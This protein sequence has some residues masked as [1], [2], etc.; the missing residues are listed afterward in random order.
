[1]KKLNYNI[2]LI[3]FILLIMLF[4][5]FKFLVVYSTN[6]KLPKVS[7]GNVGNGLCRIAGNVREY[8]SETENANIEN[9]KIELLDSDEN[10]IQL[11]D[12][13]GNPIDCI[14]SD[15]NVNYQITGIETPF[16]GINEN[17]TNVIEEKEY[18]VQFTYG[19]KEQLQINSKYN[20]Q[21]YQTKSEEGSSPSISSDKKDSLEDLKEIVKSESEIE[22]QYNEP[23]NLDIMF[24]MD[25]SGSMTTVVN[26]AKQSLIPIADKLYAKYGNDVRMGIITYGGRYSS[27]LDDINM[28]LLDIVPLCNYS[29]YIPQLKSIIPK[30]QALSVNY[31][32]YAIAKASLILSTDGRK[33]STKYIIQIGDGVAYAYEPKFKETREEYVKALNKGI[34]IFNV[35]VGNT[36]TIS[37]WW[38]DIMMSFAKTDWYYSKEDYTD[39]VLEHVVYQYILG[40]KE[41][42]NNMECVTEDGTKNGQIGTSL[43]ISNNG[44]SVAKDDKKRRAEVNQYTS[45]ID[46]ELGTKI[47]NVLEDNN[48]SEVEEIADN[49]Y[50][51][52]KVKLNV[53]SYVTKVQGV[54]LVLEERPKNEVSIS[55]DISK[56]TVALANGS[57]LITHT[58]NDKNKYVFDLGKGSQK[59]ITMDN[60]IKQGALLNVTYTITIKNTG[61]VDSVTYTIAD[62]IDSNYSFESKLNPSWTITE[63]GK[64]AITSITLNPNEEAKVDIVL[65]KILSTTGTDEYNNEVEIIEYKSNSGR[66]I[67]HT[68]PENKKSNECDMA[69]A[70]MLSIVPP[71][72]L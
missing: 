37:Y 8:I 33:D 9:I 63:N 44:K 62:Y 17:G 57:K 61:Q 68:I 1:M 15:A 41:I 6:T 39:I 55:K 43:S 52:A 12:S 72:G 38:D 26:Q 21:D 47:K 70:D 51:I 49:T 54:D 3:S 10:K 53:S 69:I 35:I 36:D 11:Y 4:L 42:V 22:E 29:E 34:N 71:T 13:N 19:T 30:M 18:I 58:P 66:R 24:I 7:I 56:I 67:Y 5:Q 25:C 28:G 48:M 65:T 2:L 46:H 64:K 27:K 50:M 45:K 59:M 31:N 16:V 32:E 60:E 23:Q 40:N 14:Y 20:G